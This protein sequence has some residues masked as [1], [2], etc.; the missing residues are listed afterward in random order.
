ME[1]TEPNFTFYDWWD[2]C[3]LWEEMNTFAARLK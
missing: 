1:G 2:G 3:E